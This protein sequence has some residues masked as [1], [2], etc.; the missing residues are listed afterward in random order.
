MCIRAKSVCAHQDSLQDIT[1][2]GLSERG[3]D[4]VE[5]PVT[6][7]T[8]LSDDQPQGDKSSA[9]TVGGNPQK[10]MGGELQPAN[11]HEGDG[12]ASNPTPTHPRDEGRPTV[13]YK[14]V[15]NSPQDLTIDV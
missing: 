1:G 9:A 6:M 10:D 4:H 2:T 3:P 12:A 7:P 5:T 15:S 8:Q 14:D 13:P 11:V